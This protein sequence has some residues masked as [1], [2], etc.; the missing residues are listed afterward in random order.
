MSS[1]EELKKIMIKY[2]KT[3]KINYLSYKNQILL[4]IN[5]FYRKIVIY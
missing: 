2:V 4:K 1:K 3:I 5:L